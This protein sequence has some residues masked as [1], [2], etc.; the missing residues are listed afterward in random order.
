MVE[1]QEMLL[2]VGTKAMGLEF[3][4]RGNMVEQQEML[5]ARMS[6]GFNKILYHTCRISSGFETRDTEAVANRHSPPSSLT[7]SRASTIDT[8][9]SQPPAPDIGH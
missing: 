9:S 8:F 7:K 6:P 3:E 2:D 1:Q 4:G 5:S